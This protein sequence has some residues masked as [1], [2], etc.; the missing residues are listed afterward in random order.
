MHCACVNKCHA[1]G[2]TRYKE[3]CGSNRERDFPRLPQLTTDLEEYKFRMHWLMGT[4]CMCTTILAM[5]REVIATVAS[6][7][8][9]LIA[10]ITSFRQS[11]HGDAHGI[12]QSLCKGFGH[13]W[14]P[15]EICHF[16][17]L[18]IQ[19]GTAMSFSRCSQWGCQDL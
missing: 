19:L 17:H 7:T 8:E 9:T 4:P 14:L 10:Q 6:H 1:A 15:T 18:L 2:G 12:A 11:P 16:H 13:L 5:K 3:V